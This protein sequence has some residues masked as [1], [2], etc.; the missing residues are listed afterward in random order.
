MDWLIENEVDNALLAM[1][2]AGDFLAGGG[3]DFAVPLPSY[4]LALHPVTNAQYASFLTRKL[5]AEEELRS[6]I[7]LGKDCCVRRCEKGYEPL[8]LREN[9]PVT[10]VSWFGAQ[11]YCE[12]AG[13]RLPSEL[14]WEKGARGENG[15]EYPWG[16]D[17]DTDKCWCGKNRGEEQTCDVWRF[18]QGQS[19]YGLYQMAGNVWEWCADFYEYD[20]YS[21]YREKNLAQPASGG[22]RVLRGGAWCCGPTYFFRGD[23]RYNYSPRER[24]NTIGFRCARDF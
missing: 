7:R 8:V 16:M 5:P 18:A 2:P 4:Y 21:R 10:H 3:E 13:L 17:W 24:L 19:P 11:A 22:L 20:A 12:W 1:I 23:N 6:W 15:F 9:H 14:E